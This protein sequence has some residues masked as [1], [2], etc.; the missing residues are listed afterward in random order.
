M[1]LK[2]IL[3][4]VVA[5]LAY[6]VY[7]LLKFIHQE[8]TSSLRHLPGPKSTSYLFGVCKE[9]LKTV[10]TN[11][12]IPWAPASV[13]TIVYKARWGNGTLRQLD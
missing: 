12:P 6:P 13:L 5:V 4:P 8:L 1:F 10:C 9:A 7:L 11:L 2:F 3:C